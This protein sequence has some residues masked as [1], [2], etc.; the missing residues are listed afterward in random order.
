MIYVDKIKVLIIGNGHYSTGSTVL[1][2]KKET[3]TDFGVILPGILE[4][5]K[6][7]YVD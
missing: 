3:N 6:Q 4:L 1:E 7:G 5:K 2:G